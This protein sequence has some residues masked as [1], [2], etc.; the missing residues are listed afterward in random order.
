MS[1]EYILQA[2]IHQESQD[3][4]TEQ[5]LQVFNDYIVLKEQT[6]ID[7][8]FG[9]G[10]TCTIYID[11]EMPYNNCVVISRPCEGKLCEFVYKIMG[12]G[13]F[14]FYEPDGKHM[15]IINPA[16]S[17]HLHE[18][19]IETLGEPVI[20]TTFEAFRELYNNNR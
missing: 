15:I 13:N 20:A 4:P 12:L 6:Y 10:D 1:Y 9:E 8:D 5:I 2:H 11:T 14:V 17:E 16:V 7:I 18:D 3:I 19:M